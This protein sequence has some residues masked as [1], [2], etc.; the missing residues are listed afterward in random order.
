MPL[1]SI[2]GRTN[3]GRVR[4]FGVAFLQ[5]ENEAS[6]S[7]LLVI[8]K[9]EV[10]LAPK[11]VSMEGSYYIITA[12]KTAFPTSLIILGDWHLNLN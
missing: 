8:F 6:D 12:T 5:G 2:S 11:L 10:V 3:C 4:V 7:W 1:L 9:R